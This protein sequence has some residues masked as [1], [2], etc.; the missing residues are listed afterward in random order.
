MSEKKKLAV[1]IISESDILDLARS[2]REYDEADLELDE[3]TA[4]DGTEEHTEKWARRFS[5]LEILI[6]S[7]RNCVGYLAEKDEC[8]VTYC[9]HRTDRTVLE[10]QRCPRYNVMAGALAWP[11]HR[12]RK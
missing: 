11:H 2:V 9:G 6:M 12:Q 8:L 3:T 5:A 10:E 1:V 7:V 4:E